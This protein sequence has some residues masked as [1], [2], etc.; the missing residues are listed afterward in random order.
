MAKTINYGQLMHKAMRQL[1]AEVLSQVARDGL[2]ETSL[3][4][5]LTI[6]GWA[7]ISHVKNVDNTIKSCRKRILIF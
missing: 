3:E 6:F 2:P 7:K 5:S 1:M 4:A